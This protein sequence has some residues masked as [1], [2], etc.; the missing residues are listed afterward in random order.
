MDQ[1]ARPRRQ[2]TSRPK[3]LPPG[4]EDVSTDVILGEFQD[5]DTLTL[6][7]ASLVINALVAKRRNDRKGFQE[8]EILAQTVDYLD[9]FARFKQKENV[10]AVERLLSSHKNLNKFERAQIGSLCCDSAEEAKTLIPSI[11]NK[12]DDDVL[13]DLLDQMA[14]LQG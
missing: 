6:S 10:E 1:H 9:A 13:Q 14:K 3:P 7:E 8:T 5:V 12:I 4:D 2:Q 11:A